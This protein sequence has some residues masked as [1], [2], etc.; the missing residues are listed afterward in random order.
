MVVMYLITQED[1][2]ATLIGSILGVVGVTIGLGSALLAL[3]FSLDIPW[4]RLC[5]LTLFL[6]G[7]LFL[8]RVL[9]IGALGSAIGLPAALAMILPDVLPP[10]PEVLVEFVLWLWWCVTL[11]LSV[12]AG[13]QLLLSPGDPLMLLRR[14]LD[15]R[16]LAV[17]QALRRLAGNVTMASP[18]VSL[19]SLAIAGMSRPLALLKTASIIH[20]WARDRHE[21][22]AAIITLVD[23]LVTSAIALAPLPGGE[24]RYE[25]LLNVAEGCE[26][27]RR[28]FEELRVPSPS[29]WRVL[30]AEQTSSTVSPLTDIERT[31]DEIALAVPRRSEEPD[32]PGAVPAAKP[33][34]FLPDAFDNPEYVHFAIKGS[35][36]ALI[37]YVLF[38][39]FDYPGIYT[40]VITCFVV[41]L[42][43]IGASNQKGLLRFGGAAVG[44]GMG[45]IALVYL[46]PN[47]E[48]I[49]GFWLVFGAGTAVAAWVNFGT[50]RI[51]YGGYQI[52]VAFYKAVL[53]G[54]GP[55]LSATV[56]RDRL[57][58]V[59]FGLIV[60]GIVERALWPV[61]AQDALRR[62]LTEIMHL[63]A[64]LARTGTSSAAPSVTGNDVDSW[65]RR[66]SQKV[67]DIQGLIE[68][69][70]FELGAFNLTEIQKLTGEAQIIFILL[71]ALARQRD[72][73][74]YPNAVRAAAAA[75]D[76]AM[77]T[78]L[79][80][81]EMRIA[82]GSQPAVPNLEGMM[83]AFERSIAAGKNVTGET[84]SAPDFSERL[85]LY[86]AL[87]AAIKRLS[88]E[89]LHTEQ[90]RHEVRGLAVQSD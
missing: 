34:L 56:I 62:R 89:P 69:S 28:A 44:G 36:A 76:N 66:I 6:F 80:A 82:S 90:K 59:F 53:Q 48:S 67:E 52:G 79:F 57:I 61:R 5:F 42:S 47:L 8:K 4:L 72:D 86:R 3:K 51:S 24:M 26:R 75:L 54:F 13:V 9:T 18:G 10:R 81:L 37:C 23:R 74:T 77:A 78:A 29:E 33:G 84:A 39:G 55:A 58:G 25:R 60:F 19:N 68:S 12:N 15:T 16:L 65:R 50:P 11:G 38:I 45:L 32:Q 30:A 7:G 1:T 35:L 87:V 22:L 71:L 49:G 43:T 73:V 64:E 21:R 17:E 40:S 85:T 88:S 27:T 70:K 31:L 63:L 41:S 14:E 83:D 20:R 46:F 2:A